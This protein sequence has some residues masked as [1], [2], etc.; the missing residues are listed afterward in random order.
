MSEVRLTGSTGVPVADRILAGA[1]GLFET[2]FPERVRGY[3]LVGS[4]AYGRPLPTSDLDLKVVFKERFRS[5]AEE[6][7]ARQLSHHCSQLSQI[8]LAPV[9]LPEDRLLR[10]GASTLKGDSLLLYGE[11]IRDRMPEEPLGFFT[12][13]W[14]HRSQAGLLA[15]RGNPKRLELPLGHP[16]P[17]GEL[18][19]YDRR[20]LAPGSP[21]RGIKALVTCLFFPA[22]AILAFRHGLRTTRR[23]EVLARWRER[24]DGEHTDLLAGVFERC[25]ERWSYRIPGDP[26]ERA[27]L[28]GAC[29]RA[30][31]FER[32][33]LEVYREFL[34]S[35]LRTEEPPLELLPEEAA[36]LFGVSPR[37]LA[38]RIARGRLRARDEVGLRVVE[39]PDA[40]KIYAL[41]RLVRT[42]FPDPE[43]D[44]V[45]RSLAA[46]VDPE[47]ARLAAAAGGRP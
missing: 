13:S 44:E 20:P 45:L 39:V 30:L 16:D 1:V 25:R 38:S 43:M 34:L 18:F 40:G 19:G 2:V 27:W 9:P 7:R 36:A 32:R 6:A 42:P 14:M 26:E 3:Y 8:D 31:G 15:V 35:E 33:F 12:R 17:E 11:E 4:Y 47:L 10:W 37:V 46:G 29:E 24:E 23:A 5:R 41:R 21:E 22:T 28:R